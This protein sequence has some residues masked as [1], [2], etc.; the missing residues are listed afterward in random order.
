MLWLLLSF[1]LLL[2]GPCIN[3]S[4]SLSLLLSSL[5]FPWN[6]LIKKKT[7]KKTEFHKIKQN[8]IRIQIISSLCDEKKNEKKTNAY[9][10]VFDSTQLNTHTHTYGT[11]EWWCNG[12]TAT[13]NQNSNLKI[14]LQLITRFTVSLNNQNDY[15]KL[16]IHIFYWAASKLT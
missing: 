5:H 7:R 11:P 15:E 8:E 14:Q 2:L 1:S 12:S 4:V 6:F 9:W 10:P 16:I 3:A 13:N